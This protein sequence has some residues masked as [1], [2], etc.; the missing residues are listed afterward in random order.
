[1]S[2]VAEAAGGVLGAMLRVHWWSGMRPSEVV[3]MSWCEMEQIGGVMIYRPSHHKAAHHGRSRLIV[4]N[5]ECLQQ[6]RQ[7]GER[8]GAV[9]LSVRGRPYTVSGY[10]QA[11]RREL[12]RQGQALWSPAVV[13]RSAAT[14]A[15]RLRGAE[16][17][18][19]L[20]GHASRDT[21]EL[22]Y[23]LDVVD[24][25]SE[26]RALAAAGWGDA[27]RGEAAKNEA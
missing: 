20:L 6:I 19:R 23:D 1:V 8:E 21:T 7:H 4:L 25:V 13:R 10:R 27:V 3:S 18:Q 16:G 9:W 17:A 2:L 22:Y 14:V 15:R 5:E 26:A 24:Y 11:L 12:R